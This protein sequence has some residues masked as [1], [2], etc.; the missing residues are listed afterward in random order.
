MDTLNK[1]TG[2]KILTGI[3]AAAGAVGIVHY[4]VT[5]M[6]DVIVSAT[7]GAHAGFGALAYDIYQTLKGRSAFSGPSSTTALKP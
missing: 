7:V 5:G 6:H 1:K 4:G 3:F 2:A